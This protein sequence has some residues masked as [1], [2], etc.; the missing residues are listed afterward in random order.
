MTLKKYYVCYVSHRRG[1]NALDIVD[2]LDG[3]SHG[4]IYRQANWHESGITWHGFAL[5]V[6][7]HICYNWYSDKYMNAAAHPC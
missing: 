3:L 7:I 1:A 6:Q 4:A 5:S 2:S